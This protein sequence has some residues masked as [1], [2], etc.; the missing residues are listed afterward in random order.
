MS[1]SS[2]PSS[3]LSA[4]KKPAFAPAFAPAPA[5]GGFC[6]RLVNPVRIARRNPNFRGG[7]AGEPK[8]F[9]LDLFPTDLHAGTPVRDAQTGNLLSPVRR[10]GHKQDE[11]GLFK[12]SICTGDRGGPIHLYYADVGDYE[13]H[14]KAEASPA[15]K[16]RF[17]ER[18]RRAHA[19]LLLSVSASVSVSV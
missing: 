9:T 6:P 3:S 11:E 1:R 5:R 13:H 2:P 10:I 14:F 15:V 16:K 19:R 18:C 12:V 17:Q 8:Y 7:G 4:S